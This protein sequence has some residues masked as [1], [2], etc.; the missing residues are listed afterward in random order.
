MKTIGRKLGTGAV[1]LGGS[2]WLGAALKAEDPP[3][4]TLP[5][6][7]VQVLP[8]APPTP[9]NLPPL[10]KFE[11]AASVA[12]AQNPVP[13]A[14]PAYAA[15]APQQPLAQPTFINAPESIA[16]PAAPPSPE[17]Q[18]VRQIIADYLKEQE[19]KKKEEEEAKKKEADA[20]GYEVGSDLKMSARWDP[21]NGVR[22]ETPNKDFSMHFGFRFQDD[23]VWWSQDRSL[24][25]ANQVG[26]LQD[27]TFF[28][29][30]RPSWDGTAWEVVEWNCELALEQTRQGIPTLDEVWVGITK[31]PILGSVRIGHMKVPQGLEGDMVSSSKAMTFLER[32]AYTDAFYQNF[33]PGLWTG[34]SVLDQRLT[35]AFMAYRQELSLHDNNGADFE[36]GE[37]AY[38]GRLTGLPIWEC[39]GRHFLHLGVSATWRK[40]EKPDPG[41]TG[42][43]VVRYRARPEMR[44]A[45]GDFG[46]A[47]L[48]GNSV[49]W[50]DTGNIIADSA[51]VY[52]TELLYVLGPFSLQAEYAW[53]FAN[54]AVVNK[55]NA[56]DLGFNGGYVQLSYFL[57][58][59]NRIYDRRL[60]RIGTTYIAR[61][62][63][64]FWSVN[65]EDGSWSWGI[66]AWELAVR[67]S[68]LDLD[69]GPIQGG[70]L[71]GWEL[72]VNWYLNT[73]WKIQFEYLHNNRYHLKP[74]QIPGDLDAFGIRT[75]IFF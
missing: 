15:S 20:K 26:D 42:P 32:A 7:T 69:N 17:T 71:D 63:T 72:G 54:N 18:A 46:T 50:V 35:W 39:D 33:A 64:P 11:S 34:N 62:F 55:A 3:V 40:G 12:A 60:G 56:G 61:P 58:G 10:P 8:Q 5:P 66:G 70:Q 49:R 68:H 67:Y 53:A 74:G 37:Y 6:A 2:L 48:P 30:I 73:N 44:D 43:A 22:F 41:L 19:A 9:K 45:I 23:W 24:R 13:S 57:T 47:P 75:Q 1:V 4:L 59:E 51:T 38:T 14:P 16:A 27:G 21:A 31:L 36:D 25:P 65:E 29:R 28:R 52:G